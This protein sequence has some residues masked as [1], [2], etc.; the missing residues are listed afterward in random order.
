MRDPPVVHLTNGWILCLN[1]SL[2]M[3][4]P[5]T[6]AFGNDEND[7]GPVGLSVLITISVASFCT[8]LALIFCITVGLV[9][10]KHKRY[11]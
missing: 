7:N 5:N 1:P 2:E 10:I 11:I 9:Y 4:N 3:F 6:T 8:I